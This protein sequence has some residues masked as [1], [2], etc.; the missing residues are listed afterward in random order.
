M[1][2]K[3][4]TL[5]LIFTT[6]ATCFRQGYL[7]SLPL[8]HRGDVQMIG[9]YHNVSEIHD[10]ELDIVRYYAEKSKDRVVILLE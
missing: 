8:L 6:C 1:M 2:N 10:L 3:T 4:I 5:L 9:E 7:D